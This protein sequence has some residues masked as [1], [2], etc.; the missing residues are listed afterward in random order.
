[1]RIM[2]SIEFATRKI[3]RKGGGRIARENI[4]EVERISIRALCMKSKECR[5]RWPDKYLGAAHFVKIHS[6]FHVF[7]L[8]KCLRL[9]WIIKLTVLTVFHYVHC[10]FFNYSN[11]ILF[12][13]LIY[14][15]LLKYHIY[16]YSILYSLW[17]E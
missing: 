12:L 11:C 14:I 8:T 15:L 17:R 7:P 4:L 2:L 6:E 3:E 1:M 13:L 9:L 5:E 16:L 10:L